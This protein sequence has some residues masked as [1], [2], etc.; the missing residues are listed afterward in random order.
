MARCREWNQYNLDEVFWF[1][2][3]PGVRKWQ[4]TDSGIKLLNVA[5]IEK[6]RTL[7]L[8]KTDRHLDLKEVE[9]RYSHFLLDAGDLVIASSGISFDDDGML[10]TRGAFVEEHHLPLCLNTSTIRFKAKP[11]VSDLGYLRHW[12]DSREF[13]EQIT[14]RV[15]GSAQQNFGP[16]HLKAIKITLPSLPEQRRIAAILDQA[17]ALQ[18]KRREALAQ[19]DSLTQ[20]IF[21]EMFGDPIRNTKGWSKRPLNDVSEQI[22]D[23]PHST[24][25]WTSDGV[26][27]LRT[28]NLSEGGW[29]WDDTRYVSEE[30]FHDRSKRGYI[31]TGDIILSREGTVGIAAIVPTGMKVCMGQRLV[32]V[33]ANKT[34]LTSEFILHYLLYVLSPKRIGQLMVGSTSQHL[35]LKELRSMQIPLP[36]IGL[37][38]SF[39]KRINSLQKV[40]NFNESSARQLDAL[41]ASLQHRA[42]RGEL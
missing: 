21:I 25:S 22:N 26:I 13:R 38:D 28:S 1:Q 20:S 37:Q 31:D 32:H 12:L 10:R 8:S 7:N 15:T 2:E 29:N 39:S 36:P 24:P 33:R 11:E 18:V 27:C 3:G 34:I 41:F 40:T 17:D 23:C 16:S 9:E 5:N 42:F 6:N 35:N 19:L 14:K 30:T 4:F